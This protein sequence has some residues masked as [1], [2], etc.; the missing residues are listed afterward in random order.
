MK[1]SI[2]QIAV[3]VFTS[4]LELG[5]FVAMYGL[6]KLETQNRLNRLIFALLVGL[7]VTIAQGIMFAGVGVWFSLQGD[8][9]VFEF[10]LPVV[11]CLTPFTFLV[12]TSGML[13]QLLYREQWKGFIRFASNSKKKIDG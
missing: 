13:V 9:R 10:L 11:F 4:L 12:S 5:L 3:F 8:V 6:F 7:T 2:F 1:V